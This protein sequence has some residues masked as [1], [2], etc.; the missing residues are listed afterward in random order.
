MTA[1]PKTKPCEFVSKFN[2]QQLGCGTLI[3]WD[4]KDREWREALDGQLHKKDRCKEIRKA[5]QE[6]VQR[7]TTIDSQSQTSS[8]H[9]IEHTTPDTN[10]IKESV[11][12]KPE[13]ANKQED[14][15]IIRTRIPRL[16]ELEKT[17]PDMQRTINL[18]WTMVKGMNS[19]LDKLETVKNDQTTLIDGITK[20]KESQDE[21]IAVIYKRLVPE[22][23]QIKPAL[24][25]DQSKEEFGLM[26]KRQHGEIEDEG[27]GMP[28][29][30]EE[31][32]TEDN[33]IPSSDQQPDE[34]ETEAQEAEMQYEQDKADGVV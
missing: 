7:Q 16:E 23:N 19:K 6:N 11:T 33:N 26:V 4:E 24:Q 32:D 9:K 29:P 18:M 28:P 15:G 30:E 27:E 22:E 21:F 12:V 8:E 2:G 17:I 1:Q 13:I 5:K 3:F 20:W 25:L 31:P 34:D 10:P 14:Q